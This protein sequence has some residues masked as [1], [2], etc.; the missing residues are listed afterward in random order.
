MSDYKINVGQR[1][2]ELSEDSLETDLIQNNDASI[3]LLENKQSYT[4]Q[5]LEEDFQN[6][7][8][9]LEIN[10]TAYP[11]E[12]MD[13]LDIKV[14]EMGLSNIA[15]KLVSA[16]HS[17]M[18]GLVLDILVK[19]GDTI[20]EGSQLLILEAMK[21]ENILKAEGSGIV[22]SIEIS[23]GDAVEKGQLLIDLE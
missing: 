17:P 21:M 7:K 2:F 20:E 9:T 10:G 16:I 15:E 3:H 6:K 11:I 19:V 12:I 22:K 1:S 13:A 18:P 8:V 5:I 23:K 14:E 4:I